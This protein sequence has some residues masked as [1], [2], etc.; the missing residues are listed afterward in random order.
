MWFYFVQSQPSSSSVTG[1]R[2]LS[3]ISF[4]SQKV[5]R[6]LFVGVGEIPDNL[7]HLNERGEGAE[8]LI[9]SLKL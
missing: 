1:G 5:D 9:L 8:T 6:K 4:M 3:V 7:N 2:Q